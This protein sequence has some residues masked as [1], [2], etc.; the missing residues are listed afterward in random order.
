M[1]GYIYA[2]IVLKFKYFCENMYMCLVIDA[3]WIKRGDQKRMESRGAAKAC[4]KDEWLRLLCT[5]EEGENSVVSLGRRRVDRIVCCE[6]E[7]GG[8]GGFLSH[9]EKEKKDGDY[10]LLRVRA[11]E[12]FDMKKWG[13][14]V[15]VMGL[16]W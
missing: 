9:F 8:V 1:D 16:D 7:G 13:N 5:D 12:S 14:F 2:Y 10:W 15:S 3:A 4:S 11:W 6:E